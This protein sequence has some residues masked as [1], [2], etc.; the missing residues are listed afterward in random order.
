MAQ[1][2]A[3]RSAAACGGM[4]SVRAPGTEAR[5]TSSSSQVNVQ[6]HRSPLQKPEK[7]GR[8]AC[9]R[10]GKGG[11]GRRKWCRTGTNG[12]PPGQARRV[13]SGR[14]HSMHPGEYQSADTEYSEITSPRRRNIFQVIISVASD[15]AY[16]FSR[17]VS[18][19]SFGK[20]A[21][22]RHFFAGRRFAASVVGKGFVR[23]S[24]AWVV[25]ASQPA[26]RTAPKSHAGNA[27]ENTQPQFVPS[28]LC[29]SPSTA[30]RSRH[31]ML[32]HTTWQ[33]NAMAR[34]EYPYRYAFRRQRDIPYEI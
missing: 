3:Q 11:A 32:R 10:C 18:K 24:K 8:K 26:A 6:V 15:A 29:S 21:G 23:P 14:Q 17:H 22:S 12:W 28:K 19:A 4:P 16:G 27:I 9:S 34:R 30:N 1:K 2:A 20:P 13:Y 33:K 25:S 7:E 5:C 31:T